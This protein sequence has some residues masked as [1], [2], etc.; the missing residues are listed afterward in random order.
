MGVS[1]VPPGLPTP[2]HIAP[3]FTPRHITRGYTL[4]SV[5]FCYFISTGTWVIRVGVTHR[6]LDQGERN[7]V[8]N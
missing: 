2:A 5:K 1:L 6:M 8:L 7:M 3:R 4:A